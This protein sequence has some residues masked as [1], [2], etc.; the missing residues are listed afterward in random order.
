MGWHEWRFVGAVPSVLAQDIVRKASDYLKSAQHLDVDAD[1]EF[2]LV[3]SSSLV[4]Q[5][6]GQLTVRMSRSDKLFLAYED[7]M[8]S[9]KRAA[10]GFKITA[11]R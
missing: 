2:D 9:N 8:E 6:H 10:T 4:A 7:S 1:I 11:H 3:L 5:Y